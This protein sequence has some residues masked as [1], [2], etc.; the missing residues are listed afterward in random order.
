MIT[1]ELVEHVLH[2][3]YVAK[4]FYHETDY[5]VFDIIAKFEERKENQEVYHVTFS[6]APSD[7]LVK[8]E[9]FTAIYTSEPLQEGQKMDESQLA[10]FVIDIIIG[11]QEG[12]EGAYEHWLSDMAEE[13]QEIDENYGYSAEQACQCPHCREELGLGEDIENVHGMLSSEFSQPSNHVQTDI[14]IHFLYIHP[15]CYD[16]FCSRI[17]CVGLLEKNEGLV[18][19]SIRDLR[20]DMEEQKRMLEL[21][22][23]PDGQLGAWKSTFVVQEGTF[24][25]NEKTCEYECLD[26]SHEPTTYAVYECVSD[27]LAFHGLGKRE[28]QYYYIELNEEYELSLFPTFRSDVS[29]PLA[30]IQDLRRQNQYQIRLLEQGIDEEEIFLAEG[31]DKFIFV[32]EGVF[33]WNPESGDYEEILKEHELT[34]IKLTT[35][36]FDVYLANEVGST[37]KKVMKWENCY[38]SDIPS[39]LAEAI[40][41]SASELKKSSILFVVN[42]KNECVHF[43]QFE[44]WHKADEYVEFPFLMGKPTQNEETLFQKAWSNL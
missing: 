41:E 26:E 23:H 6:F 36:T 11:L 39:L 12:E 25:W 31:A 24:R 35:H 32:E 15:S 3:T 19:A 38:L 20:L 21:G 7:C 1:K 4:A 17:V 37:M 2:S 8:K 27:A 9:L 42:D 30:S 22:M 14:A 18:L 5:G 33:Q 28:S 29:L 43:A 34:E 44:H 10:K 40:S 16:D 13:L